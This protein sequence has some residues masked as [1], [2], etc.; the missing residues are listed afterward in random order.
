MFLLDHAAILM[1]KEAFRMAHQAHTLL[2]N[3]YEHIGT[4]HLSIV[5][6]K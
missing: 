2:F 4:R 6:S 1:D 5:G 3:L